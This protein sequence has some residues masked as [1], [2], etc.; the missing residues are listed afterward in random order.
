MKTDHQIF[1]G[2]KPPRL[3]GY[4][5]F[6]GA[7]PAARPGWPGS[8]WW[9]SPPPLAGR[10][11][12][13]DAL[14]ANLHLDN[15]WI[16]P[17]NNFFWVRGRVDYVQCIREAPEKGFSDTHGSRGGQVSAEKRYPGPNVKGSGIFS[18]CPAVPD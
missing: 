6:Q 14:D 3:Q 17:G 13:P 10:L 16:T 4:Q 7:N 8:K 12:W 2:A 15:L 11:R 9:R 5:M 1:F 18:Q